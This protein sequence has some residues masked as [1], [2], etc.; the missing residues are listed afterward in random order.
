MNMSGLIIIIFLSADTKSIAQT[1]T[2]AI[3][4]ARAA[5]A[6]SFALWQQATEFTCHDFYYCLFAPHICIVVLPA[7]TVRGESHIQRNPNGEVATILSAQL[8]LIQTDKTT[9]LGLAESHSYRHFLSRT[10]CNGVV[11]RT[12]RLQTHNVC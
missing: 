10:F 4:K 9:A 2:V 3:G 8:R 6:Q 11:G 12:I 1:H 5:C 7:H